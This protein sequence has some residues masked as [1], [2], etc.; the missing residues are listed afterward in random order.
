MEKDITNRSLESQLIKV[1]NLLSA[2][3]KQIKKIGAVNEYNVKLCISA[4]KD[5]NE[6][7]ELLQIRLNRVESKIDEIL[8]KL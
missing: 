8:K 4:N 5:I 3:Q 2:E 1:F 6:K 7:I